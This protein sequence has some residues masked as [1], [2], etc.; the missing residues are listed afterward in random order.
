MNTMLISDTGKQLILNMAS[1]V[2]TLTLS[3]IFCIL[4]RFGKCRRFVLLNKL[5]KY[6]Y[7]DV[8]QVR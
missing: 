7:L 4:L 5:I 2:I 8:Y 1:H 3:F 6:M